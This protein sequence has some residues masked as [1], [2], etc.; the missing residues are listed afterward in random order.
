MSVIS[1]FTCSQPLKLRPRLASGVS[2]GILPRPCNAPPY[3][4]FDGHTRESQ[5]PSGLFPARWWCP[6]THHSHRRW[7]IGSALHRCNI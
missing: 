4:Q 5:Y 3:R 1:Y 7:S 6:Q 2:F